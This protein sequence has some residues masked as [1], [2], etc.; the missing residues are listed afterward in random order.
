MNTYFMSKDELDA[1]IANAS[2]FTGYVVKW[3]QIGPER[4]CVKTNY[5]WTQEKQP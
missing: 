3:I 1:L 2:W 5:V 4:F